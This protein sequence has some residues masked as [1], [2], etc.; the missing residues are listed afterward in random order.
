MVRFKVPLVKGGAGRTKPAKALTKL[1]L[2]AMEAEPA[3]YRVPDT[4]CKGLAIRVAV[5]GRKTWD[6]AFRI[7]GAAVKRVSLGAFPEVSLEAAR[8]RANAL[9]EAGRAGVD[10]VARERAEAAEKERRL[11]VAAMIE[12]YCEAHVRGLRTARET[13]SRLKRALHSRLEAPVEDLKRRDLRELFDEAKSAGCLREAEKR[14]LTVGA[15]FRWAVDEDLIESDP[16]AGMRSYGPGATRDRVL[17]DEE[18]RTLWRWLECASIPQAHSDVLKV[19][20]AIGAR[21]GEVGGMRAEEV[22]AAKWIWTLPASRSKN[23]RER[24]TPLV[25]L[26]REIVERRSSTIERDG[27]MFPSE[28]GTPLNSATIGQALIYARERDLPIKE[29]FTTHDLRRT[30][31]TALDG[32][33]VSLETIC[34]VVGHELAAG[35]EAKTLVKHYLRADKLQQKRMALEAWDRR[36]RSIISGEKQGEGSVNVAPLKRTA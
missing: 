16:M 22:D 26:A 14:R 8:K 9:T 33:G 32:M 30:V 1:G 25:G 7:K 20:L 19:Q 21:C 23:G 18:I 4:R 12:R 5:D 15:M 11:T 10:L 36:L 17:S 13:E 28:A 24:I 31:A 2:D 34:A 29:H 6:C 27:I 3:P 35:R